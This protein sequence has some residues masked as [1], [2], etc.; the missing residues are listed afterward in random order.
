METQLIETKMVN[1]ININVDT[2]EIPKEQSYI[3]LLSYVDMK[4]RKLFL[5]K[6]INSGSY[7]NI[8]NISK[9]SQNRND[10]KIILRLSK[11]KETA[12]NIKMELR[13]IKIQYKLSQINNNI[14][15][16][17]DYG[18]MITK[19]DN[20]HQEY[21]VLEKYGISLKDLLE[22]SN[23]YK[24]IDVPIQFIKKFLTCIHS[25]HKS[26]FAHLD[27]KPSNILL[28]NIN[29]NKRIIT[30]LDFSL[31]D[32]GAIRSFKNDNSK[33]IKKQMASAAFS[34]PELIDRKFGKKS[35]VWAVGV[36]SYLVIINKFFFKANGVKLFIN[37]NT[38]IIKR[39]IKKEFTKFRKII[40]PSKFKTDKEINDYLG[41]WNNDFNLDILKDFFLKIF[42]IDYTHRPNTEAL[43]NHKLFRI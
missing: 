33:F 14:G 32:F 25:I 27:L 5:C 34:P 12:D 36:I 10:N 7:N 19:N 4:P 29:R 28:K 20:F 43:L 15:L 2:D 16:V 22:K 6:L 13:G 26:G 8:Y 30:D 38:A 1:N 23:I 3:N 42:T 11:I 39:N 41:P 21:S 35:D 24:T 9:S 37:D 31:I 40:I 17:I 18:R